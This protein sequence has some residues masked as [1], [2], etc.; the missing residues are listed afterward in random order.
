MW[1]G[2]GCFCITKKLLERSLFC[3]DGDPCDTSVYRK[4]TNPLVHD[5]LTIYTVRLFRRVC[6]QICGWKQAFRHETQ[7]VEVPGSWMYTCNITSVAHP[8]RISA[9]QNEPNRFW[10][11]FLGDAHSRSREHLQP[12][13]SARSMNQEAPRNPDLLNV[14]KNP[15]W[16][17]ARR[18]WFCTSR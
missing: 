16:W 3:L 14:S 13:L 5:Q 18:F 9:N 6:H 1:V 2:P 10:Y 12:N 7:T 11:R 15:G 17:S 4:W 8:V